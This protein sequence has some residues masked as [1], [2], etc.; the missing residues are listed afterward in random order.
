[1]D[2]LEHSNNHIEKI[3]QFIIEKSIN[4]INKYHSLSLKLEEVNILI[5]SLDGTSNN[6]FKVIIKYKNDKY[7]FQFFFKIFGK[8]SSNKL[9]FLIFFY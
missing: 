2:C 8:I 5:K 3:E 6:N 1:M 4:V 7:Q 9:L